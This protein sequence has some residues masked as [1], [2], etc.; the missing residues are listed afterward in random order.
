MI[1]PDPAMALVDDLLGR[2]LAHPDAEQR[3]RAVNLLSARLQD[4][5][6]LTAKQLEVEHGGLG[7]AAEELGITR[8]AL[9]ELY[10]KAGMPGPRSDRDRSDRPA[11]AYGQWL[12]AVG[13][14]A[15]LGGAER[16]YGDLVRSALVTSTMAPSVTSAVQR[17]LRSA[18]EQGCDFTQIH[19]ARDRIVA[20]HF[21]IRE[22]L[23][24]TGHLSAADRADATIGFHRAAE[25]VAGTM[26]GF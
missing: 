19:G 17:W 25:G 5:R 6:A 1:H 9:T 22:W 7:A 26:P 10:S 14:A 18:E 15:R 8:Q 4:V 23:L 21:A 3:Y 16:E 13:E 20:A 11:T 2:L 12:A 24:R